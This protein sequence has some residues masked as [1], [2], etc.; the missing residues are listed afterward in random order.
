[1]LKIM[2]YILRRFKQ[3]TLL[4]ACILLAYLLNDKRKEKT[5]NPDE[6]SERA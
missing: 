4:V 2:S 5:N 6:D 3:A 1:M